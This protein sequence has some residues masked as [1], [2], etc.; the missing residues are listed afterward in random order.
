MRGNVFVSADFGKTWSKGEV[1]GNNSLFGGTVSE[2]S[3]VI[4]V[5]AANTILVS[6]DGGAHFKQVSERDRFALS[7]VLPMADGNLLIAGEGGVGVHK[8]GSTAG[9]KP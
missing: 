3:Q 9:E 2:Q 4:L 1:P 5:G 6:D 8:T 7:A